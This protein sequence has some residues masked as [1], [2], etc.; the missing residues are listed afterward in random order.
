M[1]L[2]ANILRSFNKWYHVEQP[3]QEKVK[4]LKKGNGKNVVK[5]TFFVL[6]WA[7]KLELQVKNNQTISPSKNKILFNMHF[8]GVHALSNFVEV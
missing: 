5:I 3:A 7:I 1:Q 2:L 6:F 8:F 4:R